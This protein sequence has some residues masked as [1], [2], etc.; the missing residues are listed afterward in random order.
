MAYAFQKFSPMVQEFDDVLMWIKDSGLTEQ[1]LERNSPYRSMK[2]QVEFIEDICFTYVI[3][4]LLPSK[5]IF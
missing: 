5:Y 1:L 3:S 4:Y 2:N